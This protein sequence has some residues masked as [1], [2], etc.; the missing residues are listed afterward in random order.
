MISSVPEQ[1][2]Q[3]AMAYARKEILAPQ[4]PPG[5]KNFHGFLAMPGQSQNNRDSDR[6]MK[7]SGSQPQAMRSYPQH[8]TSRATKSQDPG[9]QPNLFLPQGGGV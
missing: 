8:L 1:T 7:N 2:S 6:D 4:G 3:D 5:C 9:V